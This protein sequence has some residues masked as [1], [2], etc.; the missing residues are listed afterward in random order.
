M[1]LA[2][3]RFPNYFT[4]V[5]PGATWSNGTLLPSI[6]TTIEY[7]VKMMDKIQAE[8]IKAIEV[9]Q[10]ALDDLYA[11][12]DEFHKSTVWKQECR[13]WFK[14]G[15]KE[16]RIYLWPGPVSRDPF[17]SLV[18]CVSLTGRL[19]HRQSTSSSP[20][21]THGSRTITFD[22]DTRTA[23]HFWGT[24]RLRHPRVAMSTGY[25]LM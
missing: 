7:A 23:S 25:R 19:V 18:L 10:D 12:F 3:P 9:K 6:E 13:S 5:G 15:K 11:H 22:I 16:G 17:I 14:D 24:E 20:S 1:G 4:I 2:A 8:H 21:K